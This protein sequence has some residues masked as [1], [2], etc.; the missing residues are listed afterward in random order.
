MELNNEKHVDLCFHL[1]GKDVPSYGIYD[2]YDKVS[3]M[4]VFF[5]ST[6]KDDS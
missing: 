6:I 4:V 2:I 3:E 5:V 1:V